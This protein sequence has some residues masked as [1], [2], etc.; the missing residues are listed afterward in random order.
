MDSPFV[1]AAEKGYGEK[2]G[3][4]TGDIVWKY[5]RA[6]SKRES[7]KDLRRLTVKIFSIFH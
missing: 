7:G 4:K 3:K 2:F 1:T 6:W 5:G